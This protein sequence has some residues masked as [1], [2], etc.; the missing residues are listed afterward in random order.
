[1]FSG[2]ELWR[3]VYEL[4]NQVSGSWRLKQRS[5]KQTEKPSFPK[6]V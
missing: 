1:M 5:V 2:T 3:R 6:C 4:G